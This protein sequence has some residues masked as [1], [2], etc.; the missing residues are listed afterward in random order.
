[1]RQSGPC[2]VSPFRKH[3]WTDTHV[4]SNTVT[5]YPN[6]ESTLAVAIPLKPAPVAG[7]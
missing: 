5:S 7:P 1:M 2:G 3:P 4:L 6:F